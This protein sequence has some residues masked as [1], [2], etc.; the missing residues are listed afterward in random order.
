MTFHPFADALWRGLVM[1][2]SLVVAGASGAGVMFL[3]LC[4]GGT[5]GM[6]IGLLAIPFWVVAAVVVGGPLWMILHVSGHGNRRSVSVSGAAAAGLCAPLVLW[7][8]L[9]DSPTSTPD[10]Q[11]LGLLVAVGVAAAISG[12][13]A[14][15]V[16]WSLA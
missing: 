9:A 2:M 11:T 13:V 7:G 10:P 16:A 8:F 6:T 15:N 4:L 1:L 5:F 12:A 14:G 3:F